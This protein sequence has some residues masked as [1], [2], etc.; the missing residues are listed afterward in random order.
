LSAECYWPGILVGTVVVVVVTEGAGTTLPSALEGVVVVVTLPGVMVV[1][2]T[3]V[4]PGA[5]VVTLAS[6]AK[7]AKETRV[8]KAEAASNVFFIEKLPKKAC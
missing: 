1:V 4:V 2:V 7:A 5:M 8:N 3:G 6:C